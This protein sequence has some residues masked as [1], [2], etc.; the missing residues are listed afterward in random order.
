MSPTLYPV[1]CF[2]TGS[3]I[4][5]D[6]LWA[7]PLGLLRRDPPLPILTSALH[8]LDFRVRP[9]ALA[10]W[11][12]QPLRARYR[13]YADWRGELFV[14]SG[15]FAL[16]LDPHLDLSRY[17][18]PPDRLP[19]GI[20]GLQLDWGADRIA[21]LDWPIPPGLDPEEARRRQRETLE[22]ALRT[23]RALAGMP[24]HRRPRWLVPVHGTD[25]EDLAAFVREALGRL[26][27]EGLL[28]L[29]DGVAVGSLVPRR[30]KGWAGEILA[31]VR[32][33]RRALPEGMRLHVFGMN[34]SI[35]PFLM[36]EGADS[37]DAASYVQNARHL[38]FLDPRSRRGIPLAE[39]EGLRRYPC[40][41]P[42]CEGRAPR[43]D[44][45]ILRGRRPGRKSAVYAALALHNLEMD[46]EL[47]EEAVEAQRA[48]RLPAFLADLPRRFPTLRWPKASSK[49]APSVFPVVRPHSPDDYDLRRRDWQPSPEKRVLLLLPCSREKPYTASR[50]FKRIW[51]AVEKA[52]GEEARR[53]QVVFVSGLYGPVPLEE[54]MEEAVIS[55]DFRLHPADREGIARVAERLE[56][57]LQRMDGVFRFRAAFCPSP[58]YREA[59]RRGSRRAGGLVLFA[60]RRDLP[61]L[62]RWLRRAVRSPSEPVEKADPAG[63]ARK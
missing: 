9:P 23:G 32:A 14:D 21:S 50:S 43:A 29:V 44:L 37:F 4:W 35:I 62:V 13:P 38:I 19:E 63:G 27:A 45:E 53:I 8:F 54:A 3:G 11:R 42:A 46:L 25:P 31:F 7:H 49:A 59:I 51:R 48:G 33:A 39:M 26:R 58:A 12:S 36:A 41:C 34:G 20:L 16:I 28:D 40:A 55:Y 5:R 17:G 60:S 30:R 47:F 52:L 2:I 57:L 15:G 61:R 18:I 22:A 10:R 24:P 1:A 6:I 56:A